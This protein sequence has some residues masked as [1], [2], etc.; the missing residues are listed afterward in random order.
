MRIVWDSKLFAFLSVASEKLRFRKVKLFGIE[1]DKGLFVLAG[2]FEDECL[3]PPRCGTI[4]FVGLLCHTESQDRLECFASSN[5][6]LL[7]TTEP[8]LFHKPV[9]SF[10]I[11]NTVRFLRERFQPLFFRGVQGCSE[12]EFVLSGRNSPL[13]F[14]LGVET[15][16]PDEDELFMCQVIQASTMLEA[17]LKEKEIV[18]LLPRNQSNLKELLNQAWLEFINSDSCLVKR[19]Y[20]YLNIPIIVERS[21]CHCVW[22]QSPLHYL[23]DPHFEVS[24]WPDDAIASHGGF[25]YY[26]YKVDEYDDSGWGCAYR[27]I[28]TIFSWFCNNYNVAKKV[29]SIL[30][31]QVV[32]KTIDYA[33]ADLVVGSREWIGCVEAG[34]LLS[35]MSHGSISYKILVAS[36][37]ESLEELL[38]TTV[39]NHFVEFGSPVM[40]GAGS[41][42][43]TIAGLSRE[44]RSVLV[45]DPHYENSKGGADTT[46]PVR[47][48]FV[49]WK[50]VKSFLAF[51]SLKAT[52]V[53]ICIPYIA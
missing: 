40:L 23:R 34:S 8:I 30:D 36:S 52:F 20:G 1:S 24:E 45:V 12:N 33:H 25:D 16:L 15:S 49:G 7:C 5:C 47:K 38:M 41:Y 21:A 35:H 28:Q 11:R 37:D 29:P 13:C 6:D 22:K 18:V 2:W 14:P 19:N 50:H 46:S 42:A 26:H 44:A 39:L 51:K 17:N 53:N 3:S 10:K 4:K 43:Y 48:G 9:V 27:S 31:L 32:L